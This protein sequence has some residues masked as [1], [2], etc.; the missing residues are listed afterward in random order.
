MVDIFIAILLGVITLGTGYLGL[1]VTLHPAGSDKERK[2]YKFAFGA[3][4]IAACTLSG[5][6]AYRNN[7]S[8]SLLN[9]EIKHIDDNTPPLAAYLSFD[10]VLPLGNVQ[11]FIEGNPVQL[12]TY[13]KNDSVLELTDIKF[14]WRSIRWT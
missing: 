5:V 2:L 13:F 12:N 3:C 4:A 9:R 7:V 8:Q 11:A 1:H 6:Q 14:Y 10:A